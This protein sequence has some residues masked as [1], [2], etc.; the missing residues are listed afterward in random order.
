[1]LSEQ[2]PAPELRAT[3][4]SVV[5]SA[6]TV[7]VPVGVWPVV[8]ETAKVMEWLAPYEVL[9]AMDVVIPVGINVIVC[10]IAALVLGWN[11]PLPP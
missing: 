9:D 1:M 2:E 3:V 7:T 6:D 8:Y 4:Q 5:P 11:E 10:V